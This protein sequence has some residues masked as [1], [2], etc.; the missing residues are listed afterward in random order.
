MTKSRGINR[1]RFTWTPTLAELFA[2]LYPDTL[3]E[4]LAELLGCSVQQCYARAARQGL[5][6]S[7]AFF[8]SPVSGRTDGSRGAGSR[9]VK[10]STGPTKGMKFPGRGGASCFKPGRTP[11]NTMPIGTHRVY[12]GFVEVKLSD[13]PGPYTN[14]WKPVHRLV[15]EQAHGPSPQGCVVAFRPGMK[16]VEPELITLDRLECI[17]CAMNLAR[18]SHHRFGPE[19]SRVVQLRGAITR[20]INKRLKEQTP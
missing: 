20:Q 19:V 18:N 11:V 2:K 17:T 6:K 12:Q 13:T 1:P 3:T 7:E 16:T 8:A 4:D 5:G 14:R 9:F 15:W 10:G